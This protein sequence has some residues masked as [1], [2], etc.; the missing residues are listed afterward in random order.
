MVRLFLLNLSSK[1]FLK[2]VT[3]IRRYPNVSLITLESLFDTKI[4]LK[5]KVGGY[6]VYTFF[7][8]DVSM[9]YYWK[10]KVGHLSQMQPLE[11]SFEEYEEVL[12]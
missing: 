10:G 3:S 1:R 7:K 4:K 2:V 11:A 9:N 8:N 6:K 12:F 5:S